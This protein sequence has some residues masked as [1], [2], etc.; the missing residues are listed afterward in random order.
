MRFATEGHSVGASGHVQHAR[1]QVEESLHAAAQVFRATDT[2]EVGGKASASERVGQC[3]GSLGSGH[4]VVSVIDASFSAFQFGNAN[5]QRAV[6]FNRRLSE[7]SGG[8][9]GSQSN[10]ITL[11]ISR[12]RKVFKGVPE[13]FQPANAQSCRPAGLQLPQQFW[14]LF[15]SWRGM[16]MHGMDAEGLRL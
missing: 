12:F 13:F 11:F 3:S 9:Q 2:E 6:D 7:R 5:V 10:K 14:H 4:N 1:L 16:G 15:S 8:S